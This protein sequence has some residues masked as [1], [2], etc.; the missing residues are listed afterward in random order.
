MEVLERDVCKVI[1]VEGVEVYEF[2]CEEGGKEVCV[3][4]IN[5]EV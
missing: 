5:D 2:G 3:D 4:N 1:C